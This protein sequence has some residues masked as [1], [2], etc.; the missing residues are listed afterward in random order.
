[1]LLYSSVN[2]D[3]A[4]IA[5]QLQL[6]DRLYCIDC[7]NCTAVGSWK[8]CTERMIVATE[9]EQWLQWHCLLCSKAIDCCSTVNRVALSA[10]Q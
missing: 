9:F 10:V 1:V 7:I 3:I 5:V 8:K 4:Q 6:N 2:G